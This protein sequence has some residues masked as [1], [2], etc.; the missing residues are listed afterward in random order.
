MF[1]VSLRERPLYSPALHSAEY[2]SQR[3][4]WQEHV[5]YEIS[6]S[7]A[8]QM[9]QAVSELSS[10]FKQAMNYVVANPEVLR[11]FFMHPDE[12]Q[13]H[14]VLQLARQSWLDEGIRDTVLERLDMAWDGINPP[15]LLERNLGHMGLIVGTGPVQEKYIA[16]LRKQPG[17]SDANS[18]GD[19]EEALIQSFQNVAWQM[20][21][22][23]GGRVA[24]IAQ[25][26]TPKS[27]RGMLAAPRLL[28]RWA[29]KAGFNASRVV[30]DTLNYDQITGAM[31]AFTA[32]G[33]RKSEKFAD[34]ERRIFK[35]NISQRVF[36]S[37]SIARSIQAQHA[38]TFF[39]GDY[40]MYN[41][42]Q[43]SKNG[44]PPDGLKTRTMDPYWVL[45]AHNKALLAVLHELFP[46]HPN[47]LPTYIGT[48]ELKDQKRIFKRMY[49]SQG[50]ESVIVNEN[51]DIVNVRNV[52]GGGR[53]WSE[54]SYVTQ[55]FTEAAAGSFGRYRVFNVFATQGKAAAMSVREAPGPFVGGDDT[56]TQLLPV[57]VRPDDVIAELGRTKDAD[58]SR[59][60]FFMNLIIGNFTDELKF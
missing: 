52:R 23:R 47:L 8:E 44:V 37:I 50:N 32:F 54:E 16:W 53:L 24:V 26:K 14:C 45:L 3:G 57:I 29:R 51:N 55:A 49:G 38:Y 48:R 41:L 1:R 15:K 42:A 5:G 40:Y 27:D 22:P 19:L 43:S 39:A 46:D 20:F 56:K 2:A 12:Y 28:T 11:Q 6:E 4:Y 36:S 18:F 25:N 30:A 21:L 59:S 9:R 7:Q 34:L 58:P 17:F 13:N 10:M 31:V 60:T 35:G 33:Q